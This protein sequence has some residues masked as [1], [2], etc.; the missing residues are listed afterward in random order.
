PR[1]SGGQAR[2]SS[3]SLSK[4]PPKSARQASSK[5]GRSPAITCMNRFSTVKS[6]PRGTRPKLRHRMEKWLRC[7]PLR[8]AGVRSLEQAE[9]K[10]LAHG[11]G[12]RGDAE[13]VVDVADVGA[14]GIDGDPQA[15]GDL[16]VAVSLP[17]PFEDHPLP[18]G[19]RD[20]VVV[21]G[22]LRRGRGP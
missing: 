11:L 15:F 7:L 13:L 6:D 21:D 20:R 3:S 19:E 2:I 8:E 17:Q 18:L 16:V 9:A 4:S 5:P 14:D 22:D 12:L 1:I 10:G